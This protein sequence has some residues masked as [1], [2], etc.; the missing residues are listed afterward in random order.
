MGVPG[1][2]TLRLD[3]QPTPPGT[4]GARA[5]DSS[6]AATTI[7]GHREVIGASH[8][9]EP[10]LKGQRPISGV[11]YAGSHEAIVPNEVWD[12]VQIDLETIEA[13]SAMIHARSDEMMAEGA[14]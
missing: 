14:A 6:V 4:R 8:A 12:Q 1:V 3:D 9:N 13:V 5:H 7:Q 2:R 10:G 11:T